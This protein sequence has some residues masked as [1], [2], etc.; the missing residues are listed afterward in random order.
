MSLLSHVSSWPTDLIIQDISQPVKLKKL[1]GIYVMSMNLWAFLLPKHANTILHNLQNDNDV[2][3]RRND[4][5][6][7]SFDAVYGTIMSILHGG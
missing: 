1:P 7:Y 4:A 3:K 5:S 6:V 2:W